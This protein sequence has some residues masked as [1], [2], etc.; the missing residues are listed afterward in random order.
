MFCIGMSIVS[1]VYVSEI[2]HPS[3]K[4]LLLSLMSVYF[5]GGILLST[6]TTRLDSAI[7]NLLFI[8]FSVITMILIVFYVPESPIW[9]LQFKRSESRINKAKNAMKQIYPNNDQVNNQYQ[10]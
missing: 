9:L 3:Y 8:G 10:Q 5:S 4:Q 2:A 1:L 7:V 6:L